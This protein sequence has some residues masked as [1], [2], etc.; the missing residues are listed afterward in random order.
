MNSPALVPQY[1][2]LHRGNSFP[3]HWFG[4]SWFPV[5]N[6][7]HHMDFTLHAAISRR[8]TFCFHH[9]I[10]STY[11]LYPCQFKKLRANRISYESEIKL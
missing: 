4:S 6:R 7:R 8:L 5:E 10:R 9:Q 1:F 2:S 3:I 11:S